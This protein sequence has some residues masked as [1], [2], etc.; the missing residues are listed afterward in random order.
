MRRKLRSYRRVGIFSVNACV[1]FSSINARLRLKLKLVVFVDC[2]LVVCVCRLLLD[3]HVLDNSIVYSAA[4]PSM[5]LLLFAP[6]IPYE[7]SDLNEK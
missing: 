5:Q 1:R 7:E 4:H 2:L 6:S 3:A